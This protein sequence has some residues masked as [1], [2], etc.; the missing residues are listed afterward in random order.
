MCGLGHIYYDGSEICFE[1]GIRFRISTDCYLG[2]SWKYSDNW[3]LSYIFVT[4]LCSWYLA[5]LKDW[6]MFKNLGNASGETN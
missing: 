1:F 2:N 3:D 4:D 5:Y 6:D